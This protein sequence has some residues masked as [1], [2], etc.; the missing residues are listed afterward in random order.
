[1]KGKLVTLVTVETFFKSIYSGTIPVTMVGRT[2]VNFREK[3][4]PVRPS[5]L[6]RMS[7]IISY[8]L[9]LY[10]RIILV[11]VSKEKVEIISKKSC[12]LPA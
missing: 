1:M 4:G 12:L 11:N 5:I 3:K 9:I 10:E 6:P 7:K 2:V 8:N